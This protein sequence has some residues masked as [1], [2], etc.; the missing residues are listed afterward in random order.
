[1]PGAAFTPAAGTKW[2]LILPIETTYSNLEY[3]GARVCESIR[4]FSDID[5]VMATN[6]PDFLCIGAQA[7][8]T[9]WLYRQLKKH[10]SFDFPNRKEIHYFDNKKHLQKPTGVFERISDIF[11]KSES[12]F[13]GIKLLHSTVFR[14]LR[15]LIYGDPSKVKEDGTPK[16]ERLKLESDSAYLSLFDSAKRITGDVTPA[17]AILPDAEVENMARLLPHAKIVFIIRNPIDRNWSS[18]RKKL[19]KKTFKE[20]TRLEMEYF[21]NHEGVEKRTNYIETIDRYCNYFGKDN[22]L[23]AFYDAI[24]EQPDRLLFDIIEFL[25]GD[26]S[27]ANSEE[28]VKKVV[29]VSPKVSIPEEVESFLQDKYGSLIENLADRYG[30]YANRWLEDLNG[31][32]SSASEFET[33]VKP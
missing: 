16:K 22:V 20:Y 5:R 15:K 32:E 13:E 23:I 3:T 29:N 21:F 12:R 14:K 6:G 17:Y 11:A 28:L 31:I 1:M 8:G 33:T 18:Y 25:G 10:P 26:A 9:N 2:R 30:S 24:I 4:A 19:K 27:I 7:S